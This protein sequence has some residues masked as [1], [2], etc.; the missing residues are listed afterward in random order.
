MLGGLFI[1]MANASL[2][3]LWILVLNEEQRETLEALVDPTS[4]FFEVSYLTTKA[5]WGD[6]CVHLKMVLTKMVGDAVQWSSL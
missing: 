1:V 4:K 3:V 6:L 5:L 2:T